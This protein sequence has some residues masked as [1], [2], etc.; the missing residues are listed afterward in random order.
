MTGICGTCTH[1]QTISDDVHHACAGAVCIVRIISA[2]DSRPERL[3]VLLT[4]SSNRH[5]LTRM[6]LSLMSMGFP[7]N[8]HRPWIVAAQNSSYSVWSKKY[9]VCALGKLNMCATLCQVHTDN[10]FTGNSCM[11][12]HDWVIRQ[13]KHHTIF[14]HSF[15][16]SLSY[17]PMKWFYGWVGK[18][19]FPNIH[20]HWRS[21]VQTW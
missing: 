4:A 7:K 9:S 18:S 2:S 6:Y 10:I 21:Q 20:R 8:K 19:A 17:F 3:Y 11:W 5:C 15:C 16:V 13:W 14:P 1:V 12:P